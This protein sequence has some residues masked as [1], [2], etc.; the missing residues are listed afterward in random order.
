M[1]E[2]VE[3]E[4]AIERRIGVRIRARR[5]ALG[6]TQEQL[7]D[8]LGVS[9]QQVQKYENGSNRI[10]AARLVRLAARLG[11]PVA[12]LLDADPADAGPPPV[13]AGGARQQ[14]A[15]IE[16]ASGFA[17]IGDADVRAALAALVETVRER[18]G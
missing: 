17:A 13:V 18:Q 2:A 6:L 14:R 16:I 12:A 1:D 4:T 11:V 8:A 3:D 10:A 5:L 15:A 7:A 9:N